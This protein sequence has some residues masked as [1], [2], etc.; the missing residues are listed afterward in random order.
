MNLVPQIWSRGCKIAHANDLDD[1]ERLF[2]VDHR[3]NL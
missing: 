1:P 2:A 3:L